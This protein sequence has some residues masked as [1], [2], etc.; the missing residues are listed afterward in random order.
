MSRFER[1]LDGK[2]LLVFVSKK[3]FPNVSSSQLPIDNAL[4][5]KALNIMCEK[6]TAPYGQGYGWEVSLTVQNGT[7]TDIA[8]HSSTGTET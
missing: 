6:R 5:D 2:T 8:L 7:I 1:S 4:V 3:G